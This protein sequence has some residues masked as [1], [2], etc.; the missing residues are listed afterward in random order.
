MNLL[1]L[2]PGS[3]SLKCSLF[4]L[5]SGTLPEEPPEPLWQAEID[6]TAPGQPHGKLLLNV[7]VRGSAKAPDSIRDDI[8]RTERIAKALPLPLSIIKAASTESG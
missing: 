3:G 5:K 7:T 6:S 4:H 8:P 2:N 1:V